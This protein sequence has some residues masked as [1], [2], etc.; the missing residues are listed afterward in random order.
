[1]D[2]E[3]FGGN[4][5]TLRCEGTRVAVEFED[6]SATGADIAIFGRPAGAR[7]ERT[8]GVPD[9]TARDAAGG[10]PF[11]IDGPGEYEV[12]DVFVVGVSGAS[13]REKKNGATAAG[14]ERTTSRGTTIYAI[15]AGGVTV[16][17]AG[18]GA[19]VPTRADADVLGAIDVLL[20]SPAIGANGDADALSELISRLDPAIVVP[21]DAV[22]DAGGA[23]PERIAKLFGAA[24]EHTAAMRRLSVEPGHRQEETQLARLEARSMAEIAP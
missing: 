3:W 11:V 10:A 16:C 6:A 8:G 21:M 1:M 18:D 15:T 20:V 19:G 7:D 23:G 2:I 4:R 17:H 22:G 12:R 9:G 5:F 14:P 13:S 24:A